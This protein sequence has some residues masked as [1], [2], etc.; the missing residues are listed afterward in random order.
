MKTNRPCE[1]ASPNSID[2][3][4]DWAE[5]HR[6]TGACLR[7]GG[8]LLTQRALDVCSLPA[9]SRVADI[10]CGAGE[11]LE[12]LEGTGPYRAFG[13]DSSEI[14]PPQIEA[15][16]RPERFVCGRAEALPL[17]GDCFD[18]LFCECVLSTLGMKNA[19]LCEFARVLK[20]GGFLILSDVFDSGTPG[21]GRARGDS[22]VLPAIGFLKK[23]DLLAVLQRLGFGLLLWEE[24]QRLLGEFAA[25]MILAGLRLPEAWCP[26]K[27]RDAEKFD[28]SRI[29]Y[30]LL[31]AAKTSDFA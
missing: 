6:K 16:R 9:G 29:S 15:R 4:S 30:F 23:P 1:D 22:S 8:T 3:F 7:P 28:R 24:H 13:L 5:I 12:Y 21:E 19:A 27:G 11:T 14:F 10:G 31:V 25:R 2:S 26:G 20:R 18:A 17:K